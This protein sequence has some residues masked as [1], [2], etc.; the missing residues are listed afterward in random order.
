MRRLLLGGGLIA[1]VVG[2]A[3]AAIEYVPATLYFPEMQV[4]AGDA[5]T[6]HFLGHGYTG[7]G[8]CLK[9]ADQLAAPV[10]GNTAGASL[11]FTCRHGIDADSRRI[12]ATAPLPD[13]SSRMA[14][15]TTIVYRSANPELAL[16][17]CRQSEAAAAALPQENRIRCVPSGTP[18]S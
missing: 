14:D 7:E 17:A 9:H 12:L 11:R 8:D 15:G 2:F 13:P 1:G 4:A 16:A 18:R 10:K 5:L 3:L 6:I